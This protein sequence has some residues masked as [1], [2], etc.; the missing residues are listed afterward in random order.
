MMAK[1]KP[2]RQGLLEGTVVQADEELIR[3]GEDYCRALGRRMAIQEVENVRR[4]ELLD[5]MADQEVSDFEAAGRR[6]MLTPPSP[7]SA[8]LKTEVI[9]VDT[10]NENDHLQEAME[11]L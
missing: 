10:A 7:G 4:K 5:M 1:K 11:D 6:I 9:D 3:K 8:K 2:E